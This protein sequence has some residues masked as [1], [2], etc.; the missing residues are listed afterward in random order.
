MEVKMHTK[1]NLFDLTGKIAIVT[2]GGTGLGREIAIG[3]AEAGAHIAIAS[4][5]LEICEEVAERIRRMGNKAIAVKMDLEKTKEVSQMVQ[6]VLEIF[7]HIDILVNNAGIA[8]P[9]SI[10]STP[11]HRW[12]HVFAVNVA[13]MFFSS[14]EVGKHMIEQKSGKIINIASIYGVVGLDPE[15]VGEYQDISYSSSK[16]AII[17]FTRDLAVRWGKYGINVNAIS[18]A[19][20]RTAQ[21][22]DLKET[23]GNFLKRVPLRRGGTENDIKGAAVF[24][25][26]AASDYITGCNLPLDGGW[27]SV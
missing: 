26:S 20:F 13:G 8:G 27:L 15:V 6:K 16:G 17:N 22:I 25:A 10:I 5:K 23:W 7:G 12:N 11:I 19:M 1:E 3:L 18:P 21:T 4:R 9:G 2:G 14:R 24:L